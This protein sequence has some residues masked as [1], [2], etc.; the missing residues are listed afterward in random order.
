MECIG[1]LFCESAILVKGNFFYLLKE[2]ALE[3]KDLKH[4]PLGATAFSIDCLKEK[5]VNKVMKDLP[6]GQI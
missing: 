1:T 2:N 3:T 4:F 5:Y 6:L